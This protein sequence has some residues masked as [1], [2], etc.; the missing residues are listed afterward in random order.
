[1]APC[2]AKRKSQMFEVERTA[3]QKGDKKQK[4]IVLGVWGMPKG[5]K[6]K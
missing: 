2:K 6:N 1:M 3:H 4:S 5:K